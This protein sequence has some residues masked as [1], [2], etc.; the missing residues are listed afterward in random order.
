MAPGDVVARRI[1]LPTTVPAQQPSNTAL[2]DRIR[3]AVAALGGLFAG[4][5]TTPRPEPTAPQTASPTGTVLP[6]ATGN[7]ESFSTQANLD[8]INIANGE[9]FTQQTDLSFPGRGIS[10]QHLRTYRSRIR[11]DGP[12]GFGWD[13]S[14]NQR[15]LPASEACGVE[16]MI[17]STGEGTAVR[18]VRSGVTLAGRFRYLAPEGIDVQLVYAPYLPAYAEKIENLDALLA[19]L[20]QSLGQQVQD[21]SRSLSD[22]DDFAD[23]LH[24]NPQGARKFTQQ[25]LDRGV[26]Q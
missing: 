20:S 24:M 11:Y 4:Q 3:L 14:Y 7:N 15:L 23:R 9:F 5:A 21:F 8:P 18:F 26:L 2:R 22:T 13:H 1:P 19:E 10:Y 17:W 25:L 6:T 16:E 12:L